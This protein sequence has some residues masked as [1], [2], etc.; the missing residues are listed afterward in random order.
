M[1]L[2]RLTC[3]FLAVVLIVS[4]SLEVQ[5]FGLDELSTVILWVMLGDS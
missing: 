1:L 2:D 3:P 4:V 5:V